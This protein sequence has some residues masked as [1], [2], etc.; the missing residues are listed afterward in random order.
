MIHHG[1]D[2]DPTLYEDPDERTWIW[3][4]LHLG[5][6]FS[7]GA[8]DRPFRTAQACDK[9]MHQAWIAR[10]ADGNTTICLGDVSLDGC[11]R[12]HHIVRWQ[13]APGSKVLVLGNHDVDPVNR[14]KLLDIRRTALAL[15][16]PGD[17]PL[18]LTHV[19]LIQVPHGTVNVHG[20]IHQKDSPTTNRHI[21]VSVEQLGYAPANMKDIRLLARRLLEGQN[22]PSRENT[23]RRID[24][25][26]TT[27]P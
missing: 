11:L 16:A 6:G 4:D 14:V 5:H 20:H 9:A 27:M 17:P 26:K 21:N 12:P 24:I 15:A 3:S 10:A 1:F 8:F 22:V 19:P 13:Q 7:V 25:V 23:G 18:L 2:E